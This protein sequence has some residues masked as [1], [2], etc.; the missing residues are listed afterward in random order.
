MSDDRPDDPQNE[1]RPLSAEQLAIV[2]TVGVIL[3]AV[4]ALWAFQRAFTGKPSGENVG[5]VNSEYSGSV[6][7]P[8]F[9]WLRATA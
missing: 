5:P 4:Y 2:A 3:A 6:S 8:M 1:T 9:S 7:V